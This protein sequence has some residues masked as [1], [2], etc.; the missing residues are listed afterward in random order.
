MSIAAEVTQL[1]PES[2][3]PKERRDAIVASAPAAIAQAKEDFAKMRAIV[4]HEFKGCEDSM[5]C[6]RVLKRLDIAER[7][8]AF[9]EGQLKK[10]DIS[11]IGIAELGLADLKRFTEYFVT[12]VRLWRKYP[13]NPAVKPETFNVRDFG[14]IGDGKA[15]DSAAFVK[16]IAAA[17]ALAG[18]PSVIEIPAGDYLLKDRCLFPA[19]PLDRNLA[20]HI[21][22]DSLTNCV[23]RGVSPEKVNI[24]LGTY[25]LSGTMSYQCENTTFANVNMYYAET[26]FCQGTVLE[27]DMSPEAGWA[28]IRH[29]PGTLLP[30]DEKFKTTTIAVCS[31][32][33]AEGK[34]V[35]KPNIFYTNRADD[36]GDGKY[37]VYFDTSYGAFKHRV[38]DVLVGGELI[39]PNRNDSIESNR[40]Y[41]SEFCNYENIWVR[42]SRCA[43]FSISGG[44]SMTGFKCRVFPLKPEFKLSTNADTFFNSRGSYLAHCSFHNQNDDG[45]NSFSRGRI[46]GA[47]K[48]DGHTIYQRKSGGRTRK[49]DI[50]QIIRPLTGEFVAQVHVESVDTIEWR[51]DKWEAVHL[52]E[53]LPDGIRSFDSLGMDELSP[54]DIQKVSLGRAQIDGIPDFL[55]MPQAYGVGFIV[56]DNSIGDLRNVGVQIQ[57][58]NTLVEKNKIDTIY[59]GVQVSCLLSWIEGPVPYNIVIRDNDIS[60]VDEGMSMGY[61]WPGAKPF[62]TTPFRGICIENNRFTGNIRRWINFV[63]AD[64][65]RIIGNRVEAQSGILLN[66]CGNIEISDNVFNGKPLQESDITRK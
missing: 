9:T 64:D 50:V 6:E 58:P 20:S 34:Q 41:L 2:A 8:V 4:P 49:G 30:T 45:C 11:S 22:F 52:V 23:V 39:L 19:N 66:R 40:A 60:D 29:Q 5:Q 17:K 44:I 21:L 32:F 13:L 53:K 47:V 15:N 63:N 57:C 26:P 18:R 10:G 51:G 16:A 28:I 56:Y 12:E 31:Q 55:Y 33:T 61:S 25:D 38:A 59:T 37:K 54:A 42:N 1:Y 24:I 14:A 48:D 35:L 7:L 43:A 27:K 36:M 65:S 3:L 46:V 62:T